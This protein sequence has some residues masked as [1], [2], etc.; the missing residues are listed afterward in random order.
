MKIN[1][2]SAISIDNNCIRANKPKWEASGAPL[3]RKMDDKKEI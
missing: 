1:G 2:F 3:K